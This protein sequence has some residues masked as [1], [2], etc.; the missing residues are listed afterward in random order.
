MRLVV[1]LAKEIAWRYS[2]EMAKRKADLTPA[3]AARATIGALVRELR[4]RRELTL[5][6]LSELTGISVSSLSR[7]ENTR[8]GLTIEKI[9][10]LAQ[11]LD[12]SPEIL[13]TGNRPS[14]RRPSA[15]RS[16]DRSSDAARF[17]V[18][19]VRDRQTSHDRELSIEYLFERQTDRSLDCLHL[20]VQAISVWDSEFVRHPGEKIIYVISGAA[21]VYCENQ[22]PVILESCDSLYMDANV[23]HSTVAVNGRA[24]ELLVVYYHGAPAAAGPFE[25]QIFSPER[26]AAIQTA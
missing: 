16:A 24:A 9:E 20:T 15:Q 23:W 18:D 5:E 7:I 14:R 3:S 6:R 26:W 25:T 22:P 11:A 17:I 13:V 10:L 19:R 2:T 21:V 1:E 12:V 8:L 4:K